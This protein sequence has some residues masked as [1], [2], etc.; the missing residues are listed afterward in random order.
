M[1]IKAVPA[2]G[3]GTGSAWW[4]QG[5]GTA[6]PNFEA[7]GPWPPTLT[8]KFICKSTLA[9]VIYQGK[10]QTDRFPSRI[11]HWSI[12]KMVLVCECLYISI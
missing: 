5:S 3:V 1:L 10:K 12:V 11:D 4:G 8:D 7:G 2:S 9:L 6:A